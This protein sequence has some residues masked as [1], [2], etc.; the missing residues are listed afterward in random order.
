MSIRTEDQVLPTVRG[1]V[2]SGMGNFSFWI[3]K[4]RDQYQC[5][6]GMVLFPGTLNLELEQPWRVPRGC[7]RLDAAEYGGTVTVNIVPCSIFSRPAFIL[8]TEAN[9]EGRG[10][11]PRTIIEIATDIKLRDAHQL[12]DGDW[13]EVEIPDGEVST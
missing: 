5:K 11:H 12:Q 13:V 9:E 7:L 6:T 3:E 10:H 1:K 8:R 2:V 4:L